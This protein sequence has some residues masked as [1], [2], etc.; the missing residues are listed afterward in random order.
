[1]HHDFAANLSLL[2]K[3]PP[4][5]IVYLL[6]CATDLQ[7][8]DGRKTRSGRISEFLDSAK[9]NGKEVLEDSMR[10]LTSSAASLRKFFVTPSVSVDMPSK[11]HVTKA[12]RGSGSS[13]I[14]PPKEYVQEVDEVE[15]DYYRRAILEPWP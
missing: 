9:V 12:E 6:Q 1:M 4:I 2:Q 15:D 3:Y 10:M 8:R 11:I 5:D 13:M 14:N 7:E